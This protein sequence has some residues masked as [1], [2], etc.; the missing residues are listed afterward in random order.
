L[1]RGIVG[2]P[3]LNVADR[4]GE[5]SNVPASPL[6]GIF[7]DL[8]LELQGALA[9]EPLVV[10]ETKSADLEVAEESVSVLAPMVSDAICARQSTRPYDIPSD[11]IF[12]DVVT[13]PV[14][15]DALPSGAYP[16]VSREAYVPG[17]GDPFEAL[18]EKLE[19]DSSRART[20]EVP[21]VR[22]TVLVPN[23]AVP[24][25]PW[26]Q[27]PGGGPKASDH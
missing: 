22:R 4:D 10:E 26:F 9:P 20:A 18:N 5:S 3:E 15:I 11:E 23:D 16:T 8:E 17:K 25:R 14:Q 21:T 13:R 1:K 19:G 12:S 6:A 27:E 2:A 7:D 24:E